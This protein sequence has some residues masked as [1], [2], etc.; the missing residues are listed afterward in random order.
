[1]TTSE[2]LRAF[3]T[4]LQ[5]AVSIVLA[6]IPWLSARVI[7][8]WQWQPPSWLTWTGRHLAESWR[9]F[10]ADVRRLVI[11][12]V[13]LAGALAGGIWYANRPVPHYVA[14]TV[15][16]PALTE[17]NEKGISYIHPLLVDFKESAAPL[18]NVEKT[19]A[20]GIDVSPR[21]AGAWHWLSDRRLEFKPKDDWPIDKP[22]TVSLSKKGFF[23]PGV[24]LE[25]D[26]FDFRSQPFAA[27][28]AASQFYQAPLDHNLQKLV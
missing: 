7:G 3:R 5:R 10:A 26:S 15:T 4:A 22:F 17:Y 1:M 20:N 28:I 6:A 19:V 9:A 24:L 21:V 2:T 8:H 11:G 14:Y 25:G 27:K 18:Q 23:A 12:G 13:V 16:P